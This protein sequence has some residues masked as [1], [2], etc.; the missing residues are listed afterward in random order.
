MSIE[1]LG[2]LVGV[3]GSGCADEALDWAAADAAAR[4]VGLMVMAVADLPV[5]AD[6]PVSAQVTNAAMAET[7]RTAR[8]AAARARQLAPEVV[9]ETRVVTGNP[10]GE[11]L[12]MAAGAHEVVVG[13]RGHGGF[14][15]LMLGS[16]AGNIAAHAH[17]PA[18][19][20]RGR[21]APEGRV[22]V[23]VDGSDR[24]DAALEY[25][26][27]HA[28]R[29][30]LALH[31]VSVCGPPIVPFPASLSPVPPVAVTMDFPRVREAVGRATAEA[32]ERW[33]VKYPAVR[34]SWEVREGLPA[35]LLMETAQDAALLVL[36]SRGHGGLTGML[37]GSISQAAVRHSPCP[38][39]VIH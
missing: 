39:A 1:D 20:V 36:G 3:D 15:A 12:H 22:V 11:L 37:L 7:R 31:A 29:H 30:G 26:F 16:T 9:V 35:H 18:V 33:S 6:A 23:G 38:V 2:V 24:G 14:G 19:V 25:A 5:L 34:T 13:S 28:D 17:C 21:P 4:R 32:V 10:A 8:V 27:A